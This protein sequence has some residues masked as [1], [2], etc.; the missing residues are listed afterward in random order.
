MI[1][2]NNNMNRLQRTLLLG[3][4]LLA[5]V[6]IVIGIFRGTIA[7][8]TK[9]VATD[10][11]HAT[12]TA[13]TTFGSAS[14]SEALVETDSASTPQNSPTVSSVQD[15]ESSPA[16]VPPGTPESEPPIVTPPADSSGLSAAER[17]QLLA[18]H[19]SLRASVGAKAL[20][21]STSV[22][23]SAQAW[24]DT[25]AAEGCSIYH[26]NSPYGENIYYEWTTTA[27]VPRNPEKV[28]SWW[29]A[30]AQYYDYANNECESGEECGH[31][32]QL[33]WAE[34]TAVG[35]GIASCSEPGKTTSVWVCQY[36]PA[37]NDGTRPY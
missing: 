18:Q 32:T 20:T 3:L 9:L 8:Q 10:T 2:N 25:L 31:Y 17:S 35:C 27:T 15:L 5:V 14:T 13:S 19:N 1:K 22:A 29:A 4:G 33:V 12:D 37:G 11:E 7:N 28:L 30:E 21:W 36:N 16:P 23:E 26:S 6:L 34:T 24:A